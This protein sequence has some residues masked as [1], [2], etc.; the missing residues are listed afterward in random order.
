MCVNYSSFHA[1]LCDRSF[2]TRFLYHSPRPTTSMFNTPRSST[3]P[4]QHG[5]LRRGVDLGV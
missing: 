5:D 1:Y 3:R 4:Q 2:I